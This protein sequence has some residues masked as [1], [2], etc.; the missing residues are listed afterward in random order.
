[1]Y[2]LQ[3]SGIQ[4]CAYSTQ[5]GGLVKWP[6]LSLSLKQSKKY[7]TASLTPISPR[8]SPCLRGGERCTAAAASNHLFS[9]CYYQSIHPSIFYCLSKVRSQWQQVKQSC[10]LVLS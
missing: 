5:E 1:M 9:H 4:R 8:H 6:S 3:H 10:P 2:K 7:Q